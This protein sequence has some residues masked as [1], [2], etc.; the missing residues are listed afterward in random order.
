M[1]N[2]QLFG[3]Y[4]G[5]LM[6]LIGFLFASMGALVSEYYN[7]KSWKKEQRLTLYANE[8]KEAKEVYKEVMDLASRRAYIMYS[9]TMAFSRSSNQKGAI[10]ENISEKWKQ[11]EDVTYDWNLVYLRHKALISLYFGEKYGK[12]YVN[13]HLIMRRYGLVLSKLRR[14]D[15]FNQL[16]IASAFRY[17]NSLEVSMAQFNYKL[18]R[19]IKEKANEKY[20]VL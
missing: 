5:L 14:E 20:K 3:R 15:E 13:M 9:L 8:E 2:Q 18:L 17:N 7:D 16:E 4:N 10:K 12:D 6:T 1:E 11:Y 19:F